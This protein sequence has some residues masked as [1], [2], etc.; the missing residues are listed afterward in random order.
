MQIIFNTYYAAVTCKVQCKETH[1]YQHQFH[2]HMLHQ[3]KVALAYVLGF[4][5][6]VDAKRPLT[7]PGKKA[8]GA[9][10]D[11]KGS[12][13]T[14]AAAAAAA[15]PEIAPPEAQVKHLP[16]YLHFGGAADLTK[17]I[18]VSLQVTCDTSY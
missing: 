15:A 2:M 5:Q 11:S 4:W 14:A 12:A 17:N 1:E 8:G 10:Q 13:A 9:P 16:A 6:V 18:A 7:P 3:S